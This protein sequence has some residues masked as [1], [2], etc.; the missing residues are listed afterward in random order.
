MD[1]ITQKKAVAFSNAFFFFAVQQNFLSWR[2]LIC[3]KVDVHDFCVI[4]RTSPLQIKKMFLPVYAVAF[5]YFCIMH[6]EI[7]KT[8]AIL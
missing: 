6:C 7:M 3:Y 4:W 2:V 5:T 8:L 1:S